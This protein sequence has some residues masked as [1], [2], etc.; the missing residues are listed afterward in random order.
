MAYREVTMVEVK[1]VLRQVLAGAPKKLVARR[2]GM[3]AKTVRRYWLLAERHGVR[4]DEGIASLTDERLAAV[5]A[6]LTSMPGRPHGETWA[7]CVAEGDFI[8]EQLRAGVRLTKIG[9]LLARRGVLIP[10][11][12][13]H[14]YAVEEHGFGRVAA[15]VPVDDGEPGHELQLDTGWLTTVVADERGR[16]RRLRVWI[17]TPSVSRYRFVY[18]CFEETTVSAIEACEAAWAFYGGVFHVLVPDNTKALVE[19]ADPLTPRLVQGFL[20][21]AQARGFVVDPARP[22]RPTDKARVERSVSVVRDDC[23]GGELI[24]SLEGARARALVWCTDEYGLRRHS[25]TLRRPREHFDSVERAA[26]LPPPAA[27]YDVPHWSDPLVARDHFAQVQRALYSLPTRFIGKRLRARADSLTVRFYDGGALVKTHPRKQPGS[28]STD[29]SDFPEHAGH[30]A[31]RDIAWISSQ[32]KKLGPHVGRLADAL[33]DVPLPW[34]RIR[35]VYALMGLA[36]K[37]GAARV[38]AA[39][40]LALELEMHDIRRLERMLALGT[41]PEPP[42]S[43]ANVLPL[44]RY[45][46]PASDFALARPP[47]NEEGGSST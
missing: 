15:T 3:A 38:D 14:R 24:A 39:C 5:M 8:G 40:A 21:Y 19:R 9:K 29:P 6:E 16:R 12:T 45:L 44:A 23:F 1:E 25:R 13:L 33:L 18:P 46:R 35:R 2:L 42:T 43:T 32:A 20:E 37:H 22:R 47:A 4:L 11:P 26:L 30:I 36:K 41:L 34:T 17:F 7:H 31:R 27:R 10:Y 28:R